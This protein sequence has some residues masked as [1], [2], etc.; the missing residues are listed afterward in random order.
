MYIH[1]QGFIKQGGGYPPYISGQIYFNMQ[2]LSY[3]PSRASEA[4]SE[5]LNLTTFLGRSSALHM[6]DSFPSLTKPPV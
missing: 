4:T 3:K 6:I 1:C 5:S 2:H